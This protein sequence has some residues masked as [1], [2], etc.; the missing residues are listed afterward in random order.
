MTIF[1]YSKDAFFVSV[2]EEHIG[3]LAS[4]KSLCNLEDLPA[5]ADSILIIDFLSV[6]E[7]PQ[8]LSVLPQNNLTVLAIAAQNLDYFKET[9]LSPLRLGHL[10]DRLEYY[11]AVQPFLKKTTINLDKIVLESKDKSIYLKEE[12]LN[13]V[14]LTEKE[15]ALIELLATNAAP[16]QRQDIL[17]KIWG[18]DERIETKTL[19]THVYQLRKKLEK[20]GVT[21]YLLTNNGLYYLHE[22]T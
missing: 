12:P 11:V 4:F 16:M 5:G 6:P 14:K 22:N 15:F 7:T 20:L 13:T 18:Y 1:L 10:M 9:F 21:N 17:N 2:L 19:E 3:S 8:Q